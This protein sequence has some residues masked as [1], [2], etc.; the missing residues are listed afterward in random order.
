MVMSVPNPR[1]SRGPDQKRFS[2]YVTF[3]QMEKYNQFL[4]DL[5]KL[6]KKYHSERAIAEAMV[7]IHGET[8]DAYIRTFLRYIVDPLRVDVTF[9][10]HFYTIFQ[11]D[12][13]ELCNI[14][15]GSPQ[16]AE[17]PISGDL[18]ELIKFQVENGKDLVQQL[19][20]YLRIY[21]ET[22]ISHKRTAHRYVEVLDLLERTLDRTC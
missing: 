9:L 2:E 18:R 7:K 15:E 17:T 10:E 20:A 14:S 16:W 22:L 6:L 5:R 4:V 19:D 8:A 13:D 11:E 3:K 12:L 1:E 21:H